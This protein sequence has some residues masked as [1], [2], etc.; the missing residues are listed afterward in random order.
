MQ[1][2]DVGL[3]RKKKKTPPQP[4][5]PKK[6]KTKKNTPPPKKKKKGGRGKGEPSL[7]FTSAPRVKR[8]SSAKKE[9]GE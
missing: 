9:R 4:H 1:L 6:K 2:H 8:K 3:K 7:S 5:T